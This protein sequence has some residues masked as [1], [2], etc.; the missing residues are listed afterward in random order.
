MLLPPPVIDVILHHHENM[1]GTGY[2]DRLSGEDIGR[3]TRIVSIANAF[4][5]LCNQVNPAR[6]MTPY[7]A[8]SIMF[9]KM[10]KQFDPAALSVFIH[11]MGIYPPG[12]L[13]RLADDIWGMVVSV[14]VRQPLRPV[15][16]IYDPEVPKEEAILVNLEEEQDLKITRTYRPTELPREVFDYLSPR[17]RVTYYFNESSGERAPR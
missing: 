11:S 9:A 10:R 15:V 6:S 3:L 14:N 7:E 8:V 1:D 13:V 17:R 16:V 2:P 5:N 4:D 12:T